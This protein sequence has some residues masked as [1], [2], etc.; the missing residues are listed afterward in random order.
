MKKKIT[1]ELV[2]GLEKIESREDLLK[3]IA[4]GHVSIDKSGRVFEKV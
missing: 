1:A 3:K 4:L 2:V